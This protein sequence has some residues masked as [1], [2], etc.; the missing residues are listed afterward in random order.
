MK[1]N[2]R[3][4]LKSINQGYFNQGKLL[5]GGEFNW[6]KLLVGGKFGH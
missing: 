2:S 6:V 4:F 3:K 5:V 1:A